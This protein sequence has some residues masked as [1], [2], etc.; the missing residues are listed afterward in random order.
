MNARNLSGIFHLLFLLMQMATGQAGFSYSH[1]IKEGLSSLYLHSNC[2]YRSA[3]SK[4]VGCTIV[5]F[6]CYFTL[7]L[8]SRVKFYW[9]C[10]INLRQSRGEF[11]D[12]DRPS[13]FDLRLESL[14]ELSSTPHSQA[15]IE[16]SFDTFSAATS[17][18]R[19]R[20]NSAP[21]LLSPSTAAF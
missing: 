19:L 10:Q 4:K 12:L 16:S 7:L 8:T 13:P 18:R 11:P 15:E 5:S 9:I 3:P 6:F 2:G 20:R 1:L 17:S 21:S 14:L